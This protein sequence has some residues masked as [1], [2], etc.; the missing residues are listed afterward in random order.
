MRLDRAST[1]IEADP[2]Y[3]QQCAGLLMQHTIVYCAAPLAAAALE[4]SALR[5]TLAG[6][7]LEM[8]Q[9]LCCVTQPLQLHHQHSTATQR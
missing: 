7:A 5:T 6:A 8:Q 2:M 9:S 1:F 4:T 3:S